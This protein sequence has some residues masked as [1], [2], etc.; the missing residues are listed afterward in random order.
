MKDADDA[1]KTLM[2]MLERKEKIMGFGHA[3]YREFDP[4]NDIIKR[5]V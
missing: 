3:I 5:M 2:G 4:R 1:E